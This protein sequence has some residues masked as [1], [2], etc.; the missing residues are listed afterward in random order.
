MNR[1]PFVLPD[2]TRI[3]WHSATARDVWAP[4]ISKINTMW[5]LV[6]RQAVVA[7]IRRACLTFF[8]PED[9]IKATHHAVKLGDG[10]V[11]LPLAMTGVTT[12]YSS[13]SKAVVAGQPWQYRAVMVCKDDAAAWVDA[14]KNGVVNNEAVG[15]LLGYP[16]CC[17]AFFNDV[18]VAGHGVDTTWQMAANTPGVD[19]RQWERGTELRVASDDAHPYANIMLRWLGVRLVPHLPCSHVCEATIAQADAFR[20]LALQLGFT[21]EIAWVDE[22]LNWPVEWS[23]LHGIAELR[24]PVCTLST[25]TDATRGNMVVQRHGTMYP[26]EGSR[27]LRFPFQQ[28]A[29][30]RV[31]GKPAFARAFAAKDPVWTRNGFGSQDAMDAAHAVVLS[32]LNPIKPATLLDL[33]CGSGRLLERAQALGWQVRGIELDPERCAEAEVRVDVADIFN[34]DAWAD[35]EDGTTVLVMPGRLVEQPDKAAAFLD[36]LAARAS[37]VVVY[38]YGDW[39]AGT[40]IITL[41]DKAGFTSAGWSPA[42][43]QQVGPGAAAVLMTRTDHATT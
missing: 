9:L 40:D 28:D 21:D 8:S 36:A 12:Q 17:R 32:A 26:D 41:S 15:K 35:V 22:M 29:V 33:G 1:L 25:R 4:R 34:L 42:A 14:W 5:A 30:P 38:A 18:W 13:T 37:S 10:V 6:E 16:E 3:I 11:V 19:T 23:A 24:T 2:F 43:A 20:R 7:G 31:T 39:L 27:G